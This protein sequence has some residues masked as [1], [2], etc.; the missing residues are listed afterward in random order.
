MLKCPDCGSPTKKER[1]KLEEGVFANVEVCPKC[2]DDDGWID[3]KEYSRLYSLFKR[4]AF[5]I[6]GSIAVRI[7]KEI[8]DAVK[9]HDGDEVRLSVSKNKIVIEPS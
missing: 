4:K 5:K 9:L 3:E 7:P 2:K 8:A 6:G 1:Q